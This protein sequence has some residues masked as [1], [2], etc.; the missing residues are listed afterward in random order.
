MKEDGIRRRGDRGRL[1][2]IRGHCIAVALPHIGKLIMIRREHSG[3]P[4]KEKCLLCSG[5]E[6]NE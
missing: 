1:I 6:V 3:V 2:N 5:E 4:A